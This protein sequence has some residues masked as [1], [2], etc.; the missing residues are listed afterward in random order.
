MRRILAVT[1][2]IVVLAPGLAEAQRLSMG[3]RGGLTRAKVALDEEGS[4]D[5]RWKSSFLAGGFV[6]V[7]MTPA[8]RIESGASFV[9]KGG[10][11][12]AQNG[13]VTMDLD[14]LSMPILG[15]MT[16]PMSGPLSLQLFGGPVVSLELSCALTGEV[17][18]IAAD[19]LDC[20]DG[21]IDTKSVDLGIRVG[22]GLAYGFANAVS[23]F[24]DAGFE[25]GLINLNS[26]P[27]PGESAAN[28]AFLV[29][30]GVDLPIR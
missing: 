15:L 18:G 27:Q 23:L 17:D 16:I 28:R 5:F 9:R 20:D 21:G 12:L 26:T 19:A 2:A 14:Y 6:R 4:T 24:V 7:P 29:S 13:F 25:H 3:F 1:A 8:F 30:V 22:T 10:E 11:L